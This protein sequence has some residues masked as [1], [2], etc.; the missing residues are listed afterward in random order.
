MGEQQR[1]Y[2]MVVAGAVIAL[3][4]I[5]FIIKNSDQVRVDFLLFATTLSLIWLI[6]IALAVGG[7]AA[8]GIQMLA[9]RLRARESVEAAPARRADRSSA[10]DDPAREAR[11][12][13]PP[14]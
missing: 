5:G 9:R 14:L 1:V 7:V 12:E 13:P 6:L 11:R 10:Y 8:L 4:V 2:A 3:Y